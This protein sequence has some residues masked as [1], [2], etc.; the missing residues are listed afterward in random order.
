MGQALYISYDFGEQGTWQLQSGSMYPGFASGRIEGEIYNIFV[1]HSEDFGYTFISHAYN[2]FF[3]NYFESEIDNQSEI[4]Y[5][6]TYKSDVADSVFLLTSFDNFENLTLNNIF[7]FHWSDAIGLTR[8]TNSGE[9]YLFNHSREL[10]LFSNDYA[11]TWINLNN[12]NFGDFYGLGIVGG[13][14]DGELYIKCDYV[15]MMW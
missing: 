15:N 12:F 1:S 7:E 5:V 4:G 2:G 11:E 6:L 3:G 13:R 9:I 10:L 14:S 8:G